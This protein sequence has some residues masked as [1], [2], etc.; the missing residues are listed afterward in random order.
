MSFFDS[1]ERLIA[2]VIACMPMTTFVEARL[3]IAFLLR[4]VAQSIIR[5]FIELEWASKMPGDLY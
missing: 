2:S 3:T 4:I 5:K 1:L